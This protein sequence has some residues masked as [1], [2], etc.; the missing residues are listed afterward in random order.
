MLAL[1]LTL[2]FAAAATTT[3]LLVRHVLIGRLDAQL[4]AAGD[5]FSVS[6]E[7]SD[8]DEDDRYDRVQGQLAGTLGA[9][10]K[11]GKVTNTAIVG[12]NQPPVRCR[13]RPHRLGRSTRPVGPIPSNCPVWVTTG[14]WSPPDG[15]ATFR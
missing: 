5:R 6:L 12:D 2:G 3:V 14:S 1:V 8:H 4:Q 13:P 15:T 7:H 10:L 9:R 11:D